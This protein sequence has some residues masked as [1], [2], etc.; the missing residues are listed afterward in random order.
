M[1]RFHWGLALGLLIIAFSSGSGLAQAGEPDPDAAARGREA[2][3]SGSFLPPA[4]SLDAYPRTH[5]FLGPAA[6]DPSD[7]PGEFDAAFRARYGLHPAPYPNDDLPMGLRRATSRDGAQVGLHVDCLVCHGGSIG[8]TSYI[9]LGNTQLDLQALLE[10]LT[11]ADGRRPPITL[12]T[13]NSTRGTNN[14]GMIDV[15]LLSLRN[16]DLS[17]RRFPLFTGANLPELDAPAWWHL[18]KKR[19]KYYDGRTPADAVRSNMQFLLGDLSRDEFEKLEPTFRDIDAYLRSI[20]P[21]KYPF[22]IDTA[23]AETG[24][25]V[26]ES[27]CSRCHG[28]Y[29]EDPTYPN[30]IV[31]LDLIGTDPARALGLSDRFVAHFNAS[32]FGE[33]HQTDT[34]MTGYQAPPLDGIWATAPYLH[35]GSVPTLY[36]IL[37]SSERP[38][39]FTRPPS[40]DFEHYDTQRVGWKFE[41]V[42]SRPDPSLPAQEK[43]RIVDTSRFGLGNEGHTFGDELT[44]SQRMAVIVYLKS[45]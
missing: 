4:W 10:D 38:N 3:T 44:E 7:Q 17:Y 39:R 20:T 1:D 15:A 6:P 32:W 31:P 36:H 8:G 11:R 37:K 27:T 26:F 22:T 30:K 34:V 24:R 9:G 16:P 41:P 35:N 40:T 23:L 42:E 2:L 14:A 13:I 45:L 18:R 33:I 29:G 43:K 12:F 5:A 19:T 25:A 28:T 21:P